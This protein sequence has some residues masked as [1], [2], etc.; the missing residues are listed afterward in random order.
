MIPL[1]HDDGGPSSGAG[2]A[3][4][5]VPFDVDRSAATA[6]EASEPDGRAE[7]HAS[8]LALLAPA[9][10]AAV[11]L[12]IVV[13]FGPAAFDAG[14]P[15]APRLRAFALLGTLLIVAG[16]GTDELYEDARRIRRSD[17]DWSPSPTRYLIAG[18][19]ALLLVRVGQFA[20]GTPAPAE[21][22]PYALGNALV[23][24]ALSS[25]VAGPAYVAMRRRRG[26][27]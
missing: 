12:A 11:Y 25:I 4:A 13:A 20:A 23:A 6:G 10:L 2:A 7:L 15:G 16:V 26:D 14:D 3:A 8:E 18:A 24:L 22:V 27:P 5:E 9:A 1:D 17:H 21:P 19:T